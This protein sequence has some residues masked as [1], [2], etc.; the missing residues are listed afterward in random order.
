ME[1]F[2]FKL[3][4]FY[5]VFISVVA[6][7]FILW[8]CL[9]LSF[10]IRLLPSEP[11]I[12]LEEYFWLFVLSPFVSFPVFM[13]FGF[14]HIVVRYID[15]HAIL[16]LGKGCLV[17]CCL[18][19]SVNFFIG[20]AEAVPRSVPLI[21]LLLTMFVIVGIRFVIRG[22]LSGHSLYSLFRLLFSHRSKAQSVGGRRVVIV[23]AGQA[24]QQLF[25]ALKGR[26][27]YYPVAFIDQNEQ[28]QNRMIAGLR[29][30]N[31]ENLPRLLVYQSIQEILLA[32]PSASRQRKKIVI[33]HLEQYGLP[34]R[35]VPAL[36]DIASGRLKVQE[37]QDIDLGD[38]LNREQVPPAPKLLK[39]SINNKVVL[40][41]GA[42]GSI[43]SELC[44]QIVQNGVKSLILF[45]V[46]EYALYRIDQELRKALTVQRLS[47]S[48]IPVL[49]SVNDPDRL[50]DIMKEYRVQTVYHAAAYKHVPLVEYNISQG[51]RNNVMGTLYTAQAA[52]IAG[53][54]RFVLISTDK[55]V[56]PT[57]VMGASKRL[58]EMVLQALNTEKFITP[59]G[60]SL[61]KD[62][63]NKQP[64]INNTR[65][66][67][68]RF[69]NVLGSSGSVIPKFREQIK[70]GGPVTVTHPEITR[71]FMTIPEAAQLVI[72]AG[73]LGSGGEVFV[74]EMGEP[75]KVVDLAQRMITLSGLTKRD[76]EH[77]DG[78]I[79][80]RFTGLR[81]G[82]KLYEEL[83]IGGVVHSTEHS[84]IF[85]AN[86]EML[87][88]KDLSKVLDQLLDSLEQHNYKKTKDLLLNYVNGYDSSTHII[89]W[90]S[91][92]TEKGSRSLSGLSFRA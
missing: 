41:T 44:R 3:S 19:F 47:A 82:E 13:M 5:K 15:L 27:D 39:K 54:E 58:A 69:G 38:L 26:K 24:G 78:D 89:D 64:V 48:V 71:Y 67:M 22:I 25:N 51:I 86:E 76:A 84:R 85:K 9:Y 23:G 30:C 34:I 29:V 17:A 90:L 59:Y 16:E 4:R 12:I 79:D 35:T 18:L 14:Y 62:M 40:V 52:I 11:L 42:G 70:A 88:W 72:Q 57:N 63:P 75:V 20:H 91:P 56:R 49:G 28:L 46:S 81:P 7:F 74:L 6:D 37:V 43:G 10:Y 1:D 65:F 31:M 2:V 36:A 53:V 83:L 73:S 92:V 60:R 32:I 45:E 66:T 21:Y 50:L 8:M 33:Q 61:L 80:I 55:A 77:P 68:V 87:A